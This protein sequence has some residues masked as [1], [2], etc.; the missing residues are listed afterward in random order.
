M[1]AKTTSGSGFRPYSCSPPSTWLIQPKIA[2]IFQ[3][4][5]FEIFG[6]KVEKLKKIKRVTK[7][8]HSRFFEILWPLCPSTIVPKFNHFHRE[9]NFLGK[10]AF[11]DLADFWLIFRF[12]ERIEVCAFVSRKLNMRRGPFFTFPDNFTP[13]ILIEKISHLGVQVRG[14]QRPQI[15][16]RGQNFKIVTFLSGSCDQT[17][18]PR[19]SV[20]VLFCV[21]EGPVVNALTRF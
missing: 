20:V 12:F 19:G 5:F 14:L 1:A 16:L 2:K 21:P 10:C 9:I 3:G 7:I 15:R 4:H 8:E 18:R 17:V 11:S 6:V 13:S